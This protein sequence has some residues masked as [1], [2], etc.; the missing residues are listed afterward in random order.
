MAIAASQARGVNRV[1]HTVKSA[2]RFILI[3]FTNLFWLQL[4]SQAQARWKVTADGGITWD[5]HQG[6]AH[7]DQIEMSGR[8]VSVIVGYGVRQNGSLILRRRLA[9]PSL[10]TIP[11]DKSERMRTRVF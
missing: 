11:N 1:H 6:D 7:Q 10:R 3:A 4:S 2:L 9:F 8:K 5:V